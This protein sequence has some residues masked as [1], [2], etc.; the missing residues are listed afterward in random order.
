MSND[1]RI[2]LV[3]YRNLGAVE[4]EDFQ[5]LIQ[6][7][8]KLSLEE[9][10][11]Y[12]AVEDDEAAEG[13]LAFAPGEVPVDH[14]LLIATYE[15]DCRHP[16]RCEGGRE[17]MAEKICIRHEDGLFSTATKQRLLTILQQAPE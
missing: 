3:A 5:T 6:R 2:A 12:V 13:L 1:M 11:H 17:H 14:P 10:R 16:W 7:T 15:W 9:A 4:Q 8:A